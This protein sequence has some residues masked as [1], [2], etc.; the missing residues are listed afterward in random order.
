MLDHTS[1]PVADLEAAAVFYDGVLATLGYERRKQR[2]GAIGYGPANRDAPVFWILTNTGAG[3]AKAGLGLH[4]S[5]QAA[6]RESVDAFHSAAL[7][8]GGADAGIPGERP[9]YT[10]PFYGAFVFDLD[11]FKVEAVCRS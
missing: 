7:S 8:L 11:G 2:P 9:Q 3:V 5:F 10:Q 4:I 6:N 1:I